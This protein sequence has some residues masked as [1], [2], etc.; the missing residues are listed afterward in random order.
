MSLFPYGLF[1]LSKLGYFVMLLGCRLRIIFCQKDK[2]TEL[3][4]NYFCLLSLH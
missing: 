3:I 2:N 1:S 4:T